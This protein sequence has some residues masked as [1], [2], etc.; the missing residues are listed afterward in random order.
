MTVIQNYLQ[1]S[2]HMEPDELV[3]T[4]QQLSQQDLSNLDGSIIN[5]LQ[6]QMDADNSNADL[7]YDPDIARDIHE[8]I[9]TIRQQLLSF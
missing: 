9:E 1:N 6:L 4:L 5:D 8:Y 7:F 3:K 2:H